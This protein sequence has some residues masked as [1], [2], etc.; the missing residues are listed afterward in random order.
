MKLDA[1]KQKRYKIQ[2]KKFY[3]RNI[4]KL[5]SVHTIIEVMKNNGQT[6]SNF[7]MQFSIIIMESNYHLL[8]L[9]LNNKQ[10]EVYS[11]DL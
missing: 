5:D 2:R 4:E 8:L 6:M 9:N 3:V 11:S 7:L 1:M 10:I